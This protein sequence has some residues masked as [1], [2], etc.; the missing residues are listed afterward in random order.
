MFY[1]STKLQRFS[2]RKMFG[3][4]ISAQ[5]YMLMTTPQHVMS[6]SINSLILSR[7]K[8]WASWLVWSKCLK[9]LWCN[10]MRVCRFHYDVDCTKKLARVNK[11]HKYSLKKKLLMLALDV[12]YACDHRYSLLRKITAPQHQ[13][14]QP[15][16]LHH[17]NHQAFLALSSPAPST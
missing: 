10:N 13:H 7:P 4:F 17:P 1:T 2:V 8:N 6:I 5:S 16:H 14:H 15:Q 3:E 9:I 12:Y 11:R